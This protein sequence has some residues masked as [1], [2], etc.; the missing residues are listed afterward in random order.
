[1]VCCLCRVQAIANGMLQPGGLPMP[2]PVVLPPVGVLPVPLPTDPLN[3][4]LLAA[5]PPAQQKQMLGERL[6]PLIQRHQVRGCY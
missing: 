4:T 6:F 2:L 5:A 1:M 3:P